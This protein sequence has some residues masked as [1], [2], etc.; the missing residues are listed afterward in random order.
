[1]L[2][3]FSLKVVHTEKKKHDFSKKNGKKKTKKSSLNKGNL[4]QNKITLS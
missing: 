1:M 3:D 4:S 2:V